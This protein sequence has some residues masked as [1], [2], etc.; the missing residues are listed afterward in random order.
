MHLF[1][2][3]KYWLL[4]ILSI[5]LLLIVNG[6]GATSGDGDNK[7]DANAS[8]ESYEWDFNLHVNLDQGPGEYMNGFSEAVKEKTQGRLNITPRPPGELPYTG[9]ESVRVVGDRSIEMADAPVGYI[10][11]DV[12]ESVIPTWP[13]L[14]SKDTDTFLTAMDTVLPYAEEEM[15]QRGIEILFWLMDPP[16]RIWG[17]GAPVKNL[18]DLKGLKIRTFAP[19]QQTFLKEIGAT[20]VS[21]SLSEVPAALQR[22]VIDAAI[23]G[24]VGAYAGKWSEIIDWGYTIPF[25]GSGAFMLVNSE[26]LNEL[27]DDIREVVDDEAR[28]WQEKGNSETEEL[29]NKA[30]EG[31]ISDGVEINEASHEDIEMA[32]NLMQD[33]WGEWAKEGGPEMEEVLQEILDEIQ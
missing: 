1:K 11:G 5:M 2:T 29:D 16:Q 27:P 17:V 26:A 6:C 10:A 22:G 7:S 4:S 25:S 14:A 8:D 12:K 33:H 18:N 32:Q 28:K 19:E 23:T 15:D 21:M 31:F 24:A 20:P 30:I 3:K 9:M 13:F